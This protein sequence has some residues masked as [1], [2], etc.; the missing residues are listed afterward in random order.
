MSRSFYLY[1]LVFLLLS[2]L[3]IF[4][5]ACTNPNPTGPLA[6]YNPPVMVTTLAGSSFSGSANGVGTAASFNF[7]NG[8]AVDSYGNVYVTDANN[9]LIREISPGGV[10]T[11]LAGTGSVGSANG[12]GA[13]ASF[14][15]P[16]QIAADNAGNLYVADQDNNMIR[17]I[18]PGGVVTTLAGSVTSGSSNGTGT[19][20]TFSSPRGVA[21][22]T[23][24][25]VYVADS[26][27]ELIREIQPGGI[28]TTLAGSGVYGSTNATG[29]AASFYFPNGVAV[30]SAGNVYVADTDN[31]MIRKITSGGIVTTLAGSGAYGSVDGVGTAAS[32]RRPSGVAVDSLG[33]V[34][35]ADTFNNTIR[36]I[37]SLGIVTTI[38]GSA[39]VTGSTNG[40]GTATSF[41]NPRGI[42]VDSS[43]NI[44]IAD[45]WNNMIRKITQ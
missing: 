5:I 36:K 7:P 16:Y 30:D 43:G 25:N 28:V 40:I 10:V 33:Y 17:E 41:S 1:G 18:M 14:N 20:A 24:G 31:N 35:V 13:L 3:T 42:A 15:Y 12:T 19:G 11:T 34:Y 27:N 38:A 44:Y 37:T 45:T 9:Q 23:S 32:F 2:F 4:P 22:G 26:L 21:V 8:V 39:G 6:T 29:L